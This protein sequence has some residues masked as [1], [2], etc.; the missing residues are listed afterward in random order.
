MNGI[1]AMAL[2]A[3]VLTV[4]A[5]ASGRA[6]SSEVPGTSQATPVQSVPAGNKSG[7]PQLTPL[8]TIGGV[9]GV[10]L[11]APVEPTYDASANRNLAANP[12]LESSGPT[13]R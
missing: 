12:L 3:F 2:G 6:R 8:F 1:S 7:V 11:W 10:Y 13:T 9:V 5:V 4:A